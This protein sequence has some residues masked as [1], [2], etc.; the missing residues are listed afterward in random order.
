MNTRRILFALALMLAFIAAGV[1]GTRMKHVSGARTIL[2]NTPLHGCVFK[3]RDSLIQVRFSQVPK[4]MQT[5][6][7]TVQAPGVQRVGAEFQMADMDMGMNRYELTATPNSL[8]TARVMLPLCV[9]G[10]REWKLYMDIDNQRYIVP[11]MS[12]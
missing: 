9:S 8:F 7:L 5:F 11:F 1:I 10:Q 3:H 2:C 12:Q 6:T 4:P